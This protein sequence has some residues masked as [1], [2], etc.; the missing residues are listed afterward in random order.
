MDF[1]VE[2]VL[3]LGFIPI[4]PIN[5]KRLI[6]NQE[7]SISNH[8]YKAKDLIIH[9]KILEKIK[10]YKPN[11]DKSIKHDREVNLSKI[12]IIVIELLQNSKK[13]CRKLRAYTV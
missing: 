13:K 6:M 7:K 9:Y 12:V 11:W 8:L 1:D 5:I 10:H 4:C 2:L 3:R